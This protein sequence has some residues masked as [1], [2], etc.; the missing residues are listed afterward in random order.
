MLKGAV[1]CIRDRF[2]SLIGDVSLDDAHLQLVSEP[3]CVHLISQD[4]YV[5]VW[6][7]S[8]HHA[9]RPLRPRLP[10]CWVLGRF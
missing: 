10:V 6:S 3:D 5:L 2:N 8:I 7:L 4:L 9:I 1:S